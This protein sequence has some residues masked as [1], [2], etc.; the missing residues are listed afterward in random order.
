MKKIIIIA[1]LIF[2]TITQAVFGQNAGNWK[3]VG[4]TL[5]PVNAS[6]QINGIGR[7]TQLKFHPSNALKM[8]ATSA[9]GGL[10]ISIDGGNN[11]NPTSG[12]D[13]LDRTGSAAIC[14][15]HTNDQ[16]LYL[17]TGDPNYYSN[18][19]GL[20][21]STDGGQNWVG[22]TNGLGN[23]M[24]VELLMSPTN[25]N[26]IVAATTD[27]LFKTIDGG[28]SWTLKKSGGDFTKMVFKPNDA[29][30]IYAATRTQFFVS[31]NQGDSWTLISLPGSGFQNGGRIGVS[32]NDP[33]VVYL[34]FVGNFSGGTTTPVLK[35]TNS[36]QS[37]SVVKAAGGSNLNGYDGTSDG[38]GNYNYDITA[39]PNNANTVYIA[40]HV[41]W[42]STDGGI[43]WTQ[44]T[45]WY[46]KVHT[47][48]HQISISPYD[49]NKLYNVNDGGIWVSTDGGSNWTAKSD[50]LSCTECYHAAQ[51]P[52]RKDLI[53]IGTQD[54]GELHFINNG[55]YTNGGGDFGGNTAFDYQNATDVYHL[56]N[57]R[58]RKRLSGSGG[59]PGLNLPFAA[60]DGNG[61]D[62]V[63]GFSTL[64]NNLAFVAKSEVYR[65]TNIGANPPTW[66]QITTI[67]TQIK[68]I[69]SSPAD[70][71]ILYV[72]TNNGR[73]YRS[74][75]ALAATP[76]FVNLAT[77]A[78]TNVSTSVAAIKSNSNIVYLTC[79]GRAYRSQDKGATWADITSGLPGNVNISK[80]LHDTYANDESVYVG[81]VNGVYYRNSSM[82]DWIK[83]SKGLP[84]VAGVNELMLFNDGTTNSEIRVAY[85][86]RGVWGSSL[87]GKSALRDPENPPISTNGFDYKYYEGAWNVLPDFNTLIPVKTG[88]VDNFSISP[89]NR[90]TQYGLRITGFINVPTD[91]TYTFYTSTDDGSKL[92]IGSTEVVSNDGIHGQ[93]EQ[94][95]TIGLKAG[96]HAITLDYFQNTGGFGMD[97]SYSGPSIAKVIISN[98]VAFR[99]P[100]ATVCS[101]T[102][103]ITREFWS[104]IGGNAVSNIP[105]TT[106]P[107]STTTLTI[108][109]SPS[110]AADNYG[111]RIRGYICAPYTGA[112]TFWIA[113]DDDSELWLSN[114]TSATGKTR[115]AYLNGAVGSRNWDAN[116]S[117]KSGLINL[118]AGQQYYIEVLHKEGGGD[119]YLAVGWQMPTGAFER[120]IP[121]VR[122]LPY[123]PVNTNPT[124]SI[125]APAANATYI[126]TSNIT[127]TA[128]AADSDGSIAKVEFYNGT[129]LIGTATSSPY[130]ISWNNVSAGTYTITA[131]ATDNQNAS[132]T[133]AAIT[134]IVSPLR[135]PE[136]PVSTSI[137][138]TYKYYEGTWTTLPDFTVLAPVKYGVASVMDISLKNR[139]NNYGLVFNGFINVPT[140]GI[141]TFYTTS[142][143]GSSLF[144]GS[145]QVVSNDGV[146]GDQE[147]SGTIG[148]K[149]GKHAITVNLFQGVG[150]QSLSVSYSSASITK[151]T[152]PAS[153]LFNNNAS[154]VVAVTA[155]A[156]N[157]SFMATSNI[158]FTATATDADGTIAKVDFYN[159]TVLI[160]TSSVI[161]YT[162]TW[163][164]VAAGSYITTAKATDNYGAVS[165]SAAVNVIVSPLRDPE[166]PSGT[167]AGLVYKYYEGGTWSLLP[168]FNTLT[169]V[170]TA[171][172][173]TFSSAVR[174]REENFGISFT[175]F[176]TVPT[177]GIYTFFTNS[178]DG[179]KLFIGTM[180]VVSNDGG[181]GDQQRSGVMG[182]KAG[183]HAI[184]VNYFQ[185]TGPSSL[186]VA[187]SGPGIL[188]QTIPASVLTNTNVGPIVNVTAPAN[189]ASY[190]APAAINISATATASNGSISK[191]EF[192]NG[193]VLIGTS[194]TSPYAFSWTNVGAGNYTITAKAYDNLGI[195][196][197]S[198]A[199][200]LVVN[201]AANMNPTVAIT[202]PVNNASFTA[203][204]TVSI[205]TVA[206]DQDGT[207]SKVEFYNGTVL[208]GTVTASPFNYSWNNVAAGAYTIT[209]KTYD[210]AGATASTAASINVTTPSNANPVVAITS[211][212]NNTIFTSPTSVTITAMASDSDGSISKVEFYNGITLLGALTTAPYAYAWTNVPV[213][214]YTIMAKAY[215]NL[216]ATANTSVSITVK[217]PNQLPKIV[218]TSPVNNASFISPAAVSIITNATDTDGSISKVE[219]YNGTTLLG[220]VTSA[221]YNYTWSNVA[222]GSYNVTA[223]VYDNLNA[224]ATAVISVNVNANQSPVVAIT[225][226]SNNATFTGPAVVSIIATASDADGAISKVEFY[227]GA[228][229]LSTSN[230][231]PYSY[232]WTN[233]A[234]G[235]YTI[236]AKAYDNVGATSSAS[237]AMVIKAP[238]QAPVISITS[239][240][241]NASFTSPA[242]ISVTTS[243]SDADGSISK[244]EFYNGSTLLNTVTSSPYAYNWSNVSAG[245]YT[246]VVKAYDNLNA[247]TSASI[248]V[249]VVNPNKNPSVIITAPVNNAAFNAPAAITISANASDQDGTISK[250][251]FYNGTTLLGTV[252]TSP[253]NFFWNNVGAAPYT[254]TVKS[255][256]DLNATATA[257]VSITV[258]AV[259]VCAS[260]PTYL[261][262]NGYTPGSKV[263]NVG[264]QYQCKPW[265]YS[266]WCNGAAWAYAP[267]SGAYWTDAWDLVGSCTPSLPILIG[268][269]AGSE[270]S[271][272]A[273]AYPNPFENKTSIQFEL[274][275]SDNINIALY[276]S[277]G[278]FIED[279]FTGYLKAGH[280]SIDYS[281]QSIADGTY[282]CKIQSNDKMIVLKLIK[283]ARP[284]TK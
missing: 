54:N 159:G 178:D 15:D 147:R 238:N 231:A 27:G 203:P 12:T 195:T 183:K 33:N 116:A 156:N 70:A 86:G 49:N 48:M 240:A 133:S 177:D 131:K 115:I 155:P 38:Q 52:I 204:A 136:N 150:G 261:E 72:V 108:L 187:Y 96:K 14:I 255:F 194:T 260:L 85:Y 158:V 122:L 105:L 79:G 25:N 6:G 117:Q 225:S 250:V 218:I 228:T 200:S 154:P 280:Q 276:N 132:G 153:I 176:I 239:P 272:Q 102:G 134:V 274:N 44:M 266:G 188:Q 157:A 4:P 167:S 129:S 77:P 125:T 179:S 152:V 248:T 68:A 8:Y 126:A 71:N 66:A 109:E 252:T 113:S 16:I 163:N 140:D 99:I 161:P 191:V 172:V 243:V 211:P 127:F 166:N 20:L 193:T 144:I 253:Y 29:N 273:S 80:V 185:G 164:N 224:T 98:S 264:N 184:T 174:N 143:D 173:S 192:Y 41:V 137:G 233:V 268:D 205:I 213:G 94:S 277:Q 26:V 100:P 254:I 112:Y 104:G 235:N 5:F 64:Q 283:V 89:R 212:V 258:N 251:E 123:T 222:A 139:D 199:V 249:T 11:W 130:T 118:T 65:T 91:G 284:K 81:M 271:V 63:I 84:T 21:K 53:D 247:V 17:A 82:T 59:A 57:D 151:Q 219:F 60:G 237:V 13:K 170:K 114:S 31:T 42:K 217:A 241:N 61:N 51:S 92:Y 19:Y 232:N 95:G 135:T 36:G 88:T 35:S 149:A 121:A 1:I 215:D 97:V 244:V 281:N 9:T 28:V 216:N 76:S 210:N 107:S 93:V 7:I 175:G 148:L 182:L 282:L 226:P 34:T 10:F 24:A 275:A 73:I 37:F 50:G 101:N 196:S 269:Q 142:D 229:L 278:V 40:G 198:A 169:P 23:R 206:A 138:I 180:E 265:P 75:N 262:N 181:H 221:P 279:V 124:V 160:G 46:A 67:N 214:T 162:C 55:W 106:A 56:G 119:D 39:D 30:T 207:I 202:A 168:D 223:K 120:P 18:N 201:T 227:N 145:T 78:N 242:L 146:H 267:G 189:G 128:S 111:E 103:S 2:W 197:S 246:I 171:I 83:F 58:S 32:K 263:K 90:D 3:I 220:T 74:D 270:A 190:T 209:V 186:T 47:D 45:N 256:D 236:I 245:A 87:Y 230:S 69:V 259:S 141:Y 62:V 257:S 22:S 110:N 208:L 234:N 165:T 43:S